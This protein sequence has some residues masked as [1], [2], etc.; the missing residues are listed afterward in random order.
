MEKR[1]ELMRDEAYTWTVWLYRSVGQQGG[2]ASLPGQDHGSTSRACT[3]KKGE[4]PDPPPERHGQH[5]RQ[6]RRMSDSP[7]CS[8]GRCTGL[9]SS[10][11]C[12]SSTVLVG[13]TVRAPTPIAMLDAICPGS[14][15]DWSTTRLCGVRRAGVASRCKMQKPAGADSLP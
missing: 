10:L 8:L 9:L 15:A 4:L 13:H 1:Y 2:G 7:A 14:G 11:T 6:Q 12:S 5:R 3:S